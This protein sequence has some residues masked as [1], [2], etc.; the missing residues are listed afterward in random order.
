MRRVRSPL[1]A[2][3]VILAVSACQAGAPPGGAFVEVVLDDFSIEIPDEVVAGTV[4][5][6]VRNDG[7]MEHRF[8]MFSEA[9]GGGSE[10]AAA[11]SPGSSEVFT[12]ELRPGPYTVYCPLAGHAGRGMETTIKVVR[13]AP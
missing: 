7:D 2:V 13:G 1:I 11:I 6:R 5:F 8:G 9:F 10:L 3:V 4:A 12:M